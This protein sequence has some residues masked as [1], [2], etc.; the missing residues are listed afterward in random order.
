M[1]AEKAAGQ[2]KDQ[3]S[4]DYISPGS[5]NDQG[6]DLTADWNGN[7]YVAGQWYPNATTPVYQVP[8]Y[9]YDTGTLRW[10]SPAPF[11]PTVGVPHSITLDRLDDTPAFVYVTIRTRS[12]PAETTAGPDWRTQQ[13]K[14]YV[15]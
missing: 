12:S 9:N 5:Q 8:S 4:R 13:Y 14:Y 6:T 3:W 15:P 11:T 7:S 1:V 2:Y 10:T